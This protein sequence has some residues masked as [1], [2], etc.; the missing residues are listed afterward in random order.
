MMETI[1]PTICF[2]IWRREYCKT[3]K[4]GMLLTKF[5][6]SL[7]AL[8]GERVTMQFMSRAMGWADDIILAVAPLGIIT[9]IVTAIRVSG[10]S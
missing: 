4:A 6:V 5:S 3:C 9:A 2:Q 7:L 10:P 8:F 1:P